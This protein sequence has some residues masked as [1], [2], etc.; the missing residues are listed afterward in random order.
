[1]QKPFFELDLKSRVSEPTKISKCS[2]SG[3]NLHN[4]KLKCY[5]QF[6]S[7]VFLLSTLFFAVFTQVEKI[8]SFLSLTIRN[9]N[10]I[11]NNNK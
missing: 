5:S 10:K 2:G 1:M 7:T 8:L 11:K 6:I 9:H 4:F 3:H